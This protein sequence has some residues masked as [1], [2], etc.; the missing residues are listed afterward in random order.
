MFKTRNSKCVRN[1]HLCGHDALPL[2]YKCALSADTVPPPAVPLVAFQGGD[3]AVVAASSA[4]RGP[5]GN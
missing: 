3:Y 4:L 1:A 2:R 5:L